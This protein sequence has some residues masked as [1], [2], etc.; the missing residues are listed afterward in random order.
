MAKPFVCEECGADLTEGNAEIN[1]EDIEGDDVELAV[2]CGECDCT[3]Y[4]YVPRV[5]FVRGEE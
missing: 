4:A 2:Y 5:E 3:Y 1:V